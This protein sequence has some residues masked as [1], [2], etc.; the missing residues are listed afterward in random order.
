MDRTTYAP[1]PQWAAIRKEFRATR[2][3][4]LSARPSSAN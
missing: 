2:E 4:V 1:R 3:H